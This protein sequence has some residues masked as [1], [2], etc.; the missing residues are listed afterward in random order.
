M[1]ILW[2]TLFSTLA[3]LFYLE[4]LAEEKIDLGFTTLRHKDGMEKSYKDHHLQIFSW[5]YQENFADIQLGINGIIQTNNKEIYN[6]IKYLLEDST[7]CEKENQYI[8]TFNIEGIKFE[9][10]EFKLF[11]K[12]LNNYLLTD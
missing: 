7:L 11:L 1:W 6:K 10:P 9:T 2:L 5:G 12:E 3:I 4:F 8:I